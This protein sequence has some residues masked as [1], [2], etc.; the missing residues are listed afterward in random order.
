MEGSVTSKTATDN[1]RTFK[2]D[3]RYLLF[4][5]S[6]GQAGKNRVLIDVDGKPYM[7]AYDT[8][9][10]AK[11]P[12]HWR[13]IDLKLMQGKTVSVRIEGPDAAAIAQV[14][15]SDTVPGGPAYQEPDR[16]KVHFT[17]IRGWLNDPSGMIYLDGTWHLYYA[18]TRLNNVVAGPNNAWG[19]A[20]STDLL[21]W[22][23]QPTFLTPIRGECSFWTGGAAVDV[24]NTTDLG[25]PGRPAVVFS[26]NNGSDAPND[27]TQCTFVS[28]D[29]G[30]T[31]RRDPEM[32]YK[33]L[34]AEAAR[35]GGGTRDPMILWWAPENKWVMVV[36]NQPPGGKHGFYFYDSKDLKNWRET[37]VLEDM[38]ECPNLFP[39]PVDPPSPGGYGAA[40]GNKDDMRWVT[41]GSD[42]AYLVGQFDGKTFI[43]EGDKRR[44][45]FGAYSASQVFANAPGGRIVQ[46]GWAHTCDF[47]TTFSQM[48]SFPLELSLK[49]TP[50]GVR[51]F[52]DFIPELAQLRQGGTVQKDFVVKAGAALE[53]GDVTKP[54]EIVVEF[55]PGSASAVRLTGAQLDIAW[56]AKSQEL[57]VTEP[58]N[59]GGRWGFWGELGRKVRLS[60]KNGRV[61]LHIL[62]DDSSVEVVGGG[63]ENYVIEG[64]TYW[65]LGEKSPL[66]IRAEG[67][68][69]KFNLLEV[70]PLK[71]IH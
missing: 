1:T 55:E 53:T 18:N 60:P 58:G 12:D 21:H 23:E 65:K 33:P 27:F 35:R 71:S 67:G 57:T 52:G 31:V 5:C 40:R 26:A 48:A 30:M 49:S 9:I 17:P 50:E 61:T 46:I 37:S 45:H 16:P 36:Y 70:Y 10:A 3:K 38:Y 56:D 8:L 63:G 66:V 20:T 44:M 42:S 69:V 28:T 19:H 68:D 22:E 47:D 24:A 7:S 62:L 32:M 14:S 29:G 2:A 11:N 6:R 34:P 43:P 4:P 51:M 54:T 64:R 39:L 13:W 41:W 25:K 15:V 59:P